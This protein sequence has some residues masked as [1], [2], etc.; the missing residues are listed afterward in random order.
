MIKNLYTRLSAVLLGLF[1]L[2]GVLYI[3]LTVYTTRLY[4]QE[5][6]QKLNRILAQH[7]VSENILLKNGRVDEKARAVFRDFREPAGTVFQESHRG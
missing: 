4:L 5:V 2:V 7:L 6:N 1:L 3:V